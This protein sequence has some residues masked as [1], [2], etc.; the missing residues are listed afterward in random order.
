MREGYIREEK[1]IE[2]T[3]I[4]KEMDIIT[5]IVKTQNELKVANK[6]FEYAQDELVDYYVYEI[7]A[8]QAKL[9]YLIRIAKIKGIQ[10][11]MIKEVK[12][13]FMILQDGEEAV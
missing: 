8:I 1:L 13:N 5:D 3:E 4:Q 7:K 10:S 9:N 11:D 6:N 2:K 12:Y